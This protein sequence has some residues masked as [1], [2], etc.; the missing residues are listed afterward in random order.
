MKRSSAEEEEGS[1][2]LPGDGAV[3]DR[4]DGSFG[5]PVDKQDTRHVSESRKAGIRGDRLNDTILVNKQTNT[6]CIWSGI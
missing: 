3:L 6:G 5:S 1:G 4:E 2:G